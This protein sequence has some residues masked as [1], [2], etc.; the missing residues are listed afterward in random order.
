MPQALS[1]EQL[2]LDL[3]DPDEGPHAIQLVAERAIAALAAAWSCQV[4]WCRLPRIV[5]IEDN[6][7]NLRYDVGDV[8][9]DARYTRYVDDQRML[10]SHSSAMIPPVLRALAVEPAQRRMCCWCARAS[11]T[12]ATPSTG[13]TPAHRTSWTCGGCPGAHRR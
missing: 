4:R 12:G 2:S 11:S 9:R 7:D 1:A 3:S 8:T 13:C 6:Y 5:A 10:R